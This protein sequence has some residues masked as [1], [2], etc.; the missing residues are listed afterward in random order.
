MK[1][2]WSYLRYKHACEWFHMIPLDYQG[3]L[4]LLDEYNGIKLV[5]TT[6]QAFIL[7]TPNPSDNM[8]DLRCKYSWRLTAIEE[9]LAHC[10]EV[11]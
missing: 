4:D 6:I 11:A 1:K 7:N 3:W 8:L 10:L 9:K 2:W 5:L